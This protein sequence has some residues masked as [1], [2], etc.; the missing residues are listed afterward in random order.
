MF[1]GLGPNRKLFKLIRRL[2]LFDN[3][4]LGLFFVYV[5]LYL[6]LLNVIYLILFYISLQYNCFV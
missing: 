5:S 2:V 1:I 6:I 3:I 4:V